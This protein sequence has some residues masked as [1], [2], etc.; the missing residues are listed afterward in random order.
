MG[1][2]VRGRT[3]ARGGRLER[4]MRRLLSGAALLLASCAGCNGEPRVVA[5]LHWGGF[6]PGCL[7]LR[8][9]P[10]GATRGATVTF[11]LEQP[12]RAG[13]RRVAV[14]TPQGQGPLVALVGEALEHDCDGG[15]VARAEEEIQA[16]SSGP[17][18]TLALSAN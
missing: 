13:A 9:P 12:E 8:A 10:A 4:V 1:P 18:R 3:G 11:P 7:V 15:V 5:V 17:E 16:D 6:P 2:A 14:F